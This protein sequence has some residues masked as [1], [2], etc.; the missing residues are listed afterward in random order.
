MLSLPVE[1]LLGK[2]RKGHYDL[3]TAAGESPGLK[4][5]NVWKDYP[6]PQMKRENWMSL[7]GTWMLDGDQIRVPFPP[8]SQ[9]SNYGKKVKEHF[10][11][12]K[13]FTIAGILKGERILLHF[14]AVDQIAEVVLNGK[15]LG[16]H[17]GGYLAFSFDVTDCIKRVGENVLQVK[18]TDKLDRTYP[19]GKQ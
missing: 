13:Q 9:L 18:V 7:N 12:E 1:M 16:I 11:Y 15:T 8:Q 19:Y 14:G 10:T 3:S 17:E 4:E 5:E 2:F 6:R